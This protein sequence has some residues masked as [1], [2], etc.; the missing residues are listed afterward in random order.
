MLKIN[1]VQPDTGKRYALT[2]ENAVSRYKADQQ[3]ADA[4][5]TLTVPRAAL[6]GALLGQT[7]LRDE[8]GAG[9][10]KIDGDPAALQAWLGMLDKFDPQ[11]EVVAP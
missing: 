7:T 2:V 6:V 5:A 10:A 3:H 8:A 9:R 11:F 1:W 4:Q